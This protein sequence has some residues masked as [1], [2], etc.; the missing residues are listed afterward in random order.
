MPCEARPR[1]RPK[2]DHALRQVT[3]AVH[4]G[5]APTNTSAMDTS[6]AQLRMTGRTAV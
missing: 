1:K 6:P 4:T 2:P 3:D 5:F